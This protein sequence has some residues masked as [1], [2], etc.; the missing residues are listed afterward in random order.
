MASSSLLDRYKPTSDQLQSLYSSLPSTVRTHI[1]TVLDLVQRSLP[2]QKQPEQQATF[3]EKAVAKYSEINTTTLIALL[4]PLIFFLGALMSWWPS[5]GRYSPFTS[6]YNRSGPPQ[7]TTDDY[8]YLRGDDDR[9]AEPIRQ[10]S[11]GFPSQYNTTSSRHPSHQPR[12]ESRTSPRLD[13]DAD[14]EP[15]VIILKHKGQTYPLPFPAFSISEARLNVRDLRR[16]AAHQLDVDDPR[17]VKLLYKGKQM[18]DDASTCRHEN[19]KQNSEVMCVVSSEP[20][21][22]DGGSSDSDEGSDSVTAANGLGIDASSRDDGKKKRK[23]HR[24]GKKKR[25]REEGV[26]PE[27]DS[28]PAANLAPPAASGPATSRNASPSPAKKPS[29]P[30]EMLESIELN[31]T[32]SLLPLIEVFLASPPN[33]KKARDQEYKKLSETTLAQVLIKLDG[34][35]TMGDDHLRNKRRELVKYVQSWLNK[36]DAYKPKEG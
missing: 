19:L 1:A 35:E 7:I 36:L 6:F 28:R 8:S 11:Y 33:D 2:H 29:T 13:D 20:M 31:F 30:G 21:R 16:A 26:R 23:N 9:S 18:R 12:H 34:V 5:S 25:E 14:L 10:D 3:L 4:A 27:G 15:D 22:A 17:R 24:S 32:D